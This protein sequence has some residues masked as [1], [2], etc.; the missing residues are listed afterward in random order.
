[1]SWLVSST[2]FSISGLLLLRLVF[3]SVFYFRRKTVSLLMVGVWQTFRSIWRIGPT[4]KDTHRREKLHMPCLSQEV[5]EIWP[6]QVS[7]CCTFTNTSISLAFWLINK[8]KY[9]EHSVM[10]IRH[11][12]KKVVKGI[13]NIFF[14]WASFWK[15]ICHCQ[16]QCIFCTENAI[17]YLQTLKVKKSCSHLMTV[18]ELE[19]TMIGYQLL[20]FY[21][22]TK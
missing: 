16:S 22:I 21:K 4:H 5:Y 9:P 20:W 18:F 7:Y 17:T 1:M 2:R 19:C 13:A 11:N 12:F 10:F 8:N 14:L 6:P 15:D 3:K